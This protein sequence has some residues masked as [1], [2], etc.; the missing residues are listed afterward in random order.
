MSA[1]L[2]AL[3][4]ARDIRVTAEQQKAAEEKAAAEVKAKKTRKIALI[5]TPIVVV[6][7]VAAVLISNIVKKNQTEDAYHAA[8]SMVEEGRYDEAIAAFSELGDYKDS[9]QQLENARKEAAIEKANAEAYADAA[10]W[11]ETG[12]LIEA[13]DAFAVLGD[14]RDSAECLSQCQAALY[15]EAVTLMETGKFAKAYDLFVVLGDYQ[16]SAQHLETCSKAYVMLSKTNDYC[17]ITY[18]YSNGLLVRETAVGTSTKN[19]AFQGFSFSAG[20]RGVAE[21][22]YDTNGNVIEIRVIREDGVVILTINKSYDSKG[23]MIRDTYAYDSKNFTDY[24]HLYTYDGNGNVIHQEWYQNLDGTG[25]VYYYKNN[26]YDEHNQLT[27][28]EYKY[29]WDKLN[30]VTYENEYDANGWLTRQTLTYSVTGNVITKEFEYDE[31]GNVLVQRSIDANSQNETHYT[32]D[33]YD[34]VIKEEYINKDTVST[35]IYTYGIVD[36]YK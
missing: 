12:A 11:M 13:M 31:N 1:D 34:N 22:D 19:F 29:E 21:Y 25:E 14:Y 32:Y 18:E 4:K 6:L 3:K 2:E 10:Q 26:T 35:T 30:K 8:V 15:A 5:V 20:S 17:E 33:E 16:D 28:Q 36:M 9:V 23:N 24:T 27:Y 7:I